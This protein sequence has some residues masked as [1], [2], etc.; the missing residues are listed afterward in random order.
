MP[1]NLS[2][3]IELMIPVEDRKCREKLIDILKTCLKDTCKGRFMQADGS[4]T[5]AASAEPASRAQDVLCREACR[6]V[7][8]LRRSKRTKFEPHLPPGSSA[9]APD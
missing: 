9:S 2:R 3:R 8:D 7:E 4:Y 5:R 6:N 1:R